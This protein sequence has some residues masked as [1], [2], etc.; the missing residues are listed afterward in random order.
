MDSLK[1]SA[2]F[3]VLHDVVIK[4]RNCPHFRS[5]GNLFRDHQVASTALYSWHGHWCMLLKICVCRK[6]WIY[7]IRIMTT[8]GGPP[9]CRFESSGFSSVA[10]CWPKLTWSAHFVK[11]L[12][13]RRIRC[14]ISDL[15]LLNSYYLVL[16]KLRPKLYGINNVRYRPRSTEATRCCHCISA[17]SRGSVARWE[18]AR[19]LEYSEGG[20]QYRSQEYCRERETESSGSTRNNSRA[21]MLQHATRQNFKWYKLNRYRN[22]RIVIRDKKRR[23]EES[24]H[25]VMELMYR[26]QSRIL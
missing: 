11:S 15:K 22:S 8:S 2:N 7:Q 26:F 3:E 20:H 12:A 21:V 5:P 19:L 13:Q 14:F 9:E 23:L 4:Y 6:A 10:S 16:I 17:E 25:E 24:E 1:N 18:C